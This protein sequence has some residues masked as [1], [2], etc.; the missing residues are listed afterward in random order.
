MYKEY[1]FSIFDTVIKNSKHL[2]NNIDNRKLCMYI[3][4]N[5]HTIQ[6]KCNILS[7]LY[8]NTIQ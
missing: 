8:V 7:T 5:Y 2:V 4:Y 1:F 6:N 3:E